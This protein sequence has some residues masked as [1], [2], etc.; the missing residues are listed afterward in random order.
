MGESP[1]RIELQCFATLIERC[2]VLPHKEKESRATETKPGRQRI[3]IDRASHLGKRLFIA[4]EQNQ[5][6]RVVSV[7][8]GKVRAQLQTATEIPFRTWP[9]A[10]DI[11]FVGRQRVVGFTKRRV[12]FQRFLRV[13]FLRFGPFLFGWQESESEGEAVKIGKARI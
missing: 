11:E 2:V 3:E 6:K 13:V 7:H 5:T 1:T 9:I 8:F 12:E 10:M 4:A